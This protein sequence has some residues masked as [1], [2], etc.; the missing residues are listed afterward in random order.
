M[1]FQS[2]VVQFIPDDPNAPIASDYITHEDDGRFEIAT[3][4]G[5]V[6]EAYRVEVVRVAAAFRAAPSMDGA[7][8][9]DGPRYDLTPEADELA[10]EL[11]TADL[12]ASSP[13]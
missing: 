13:E 6:A 5:P 2:I 12:K 1:D 7:E 9:F 11:T 3:E 10:I 4:H 8:H